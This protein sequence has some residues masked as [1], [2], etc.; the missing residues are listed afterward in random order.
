MVLELSCEYRTSM[1]FKLL[2]IY[3]RIII[4]L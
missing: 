2:L 3:I 1:K 4:I